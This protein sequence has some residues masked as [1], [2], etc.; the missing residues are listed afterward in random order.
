VE[1]QSTNVTAHVDCPGHADYVKNT[2]A[3][4]MDRVWCRRRTDAAT[5]EHIAGRQV[6][7]PSFFF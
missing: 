3:A 1:Y 2:G 5:R 6:N 7:V 4:Q